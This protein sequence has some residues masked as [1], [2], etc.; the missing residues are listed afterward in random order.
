MI[1]YNA[2][3]TILGTVHH[4]EQKPKILALIEDLNRHFS[5]ED[6]E[7]A[8]RHM[9]KCSSSLIIREMQIKTTLRHDLTPV[10]MAII[11]KSISN[12][13]KR[14][15]PVVA[16]WLMNLTSNHEVTGWIPGLAQW[17]KDQALPWAVV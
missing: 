4:S 2:A 9:K 14:R 17:V 16:Q 3:G 15:L 5:K 7:M 11:K 1:S 12:K 10:S 13:K 6:M 8:N